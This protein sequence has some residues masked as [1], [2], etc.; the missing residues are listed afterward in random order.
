MKAFRFFSLFQLVNLSLSIQLLIAT[1]SAAN[2]GDLVT[3]FNTDGTTNEADLLL[4]MQS[5]GS[6]KGDPDYKLLQDLDQ[7]DDIDNFD[8]LLFIAAWKEDNQ[9]RSPRTLADV[10]NLM[11]FEDFLN[12]TPWRLGCVTNED[13]AC[14]NVVRVVSAGPAITVKG[15]PAIPV[16]YGPENEAPW[17][18]FYLDLENSL[19]IL[20]ADIDRPVTNLPGVSVQP[21]PLEM[22]GPVALIDSAMPT[23][24][25]RTV[26]SGTGSV[27]GDVILPPKLLGLFGMDDKIGPI[28]EDCEFDCGCEIDNLC[29]ELFSLLLVA[30]GH[31]SAQ[32]VFLNLG[33]GNIA[34]ITG[35]LEVSWEMIFDTG[36]LQFANLSYQFLGL[37]KFLAL[38]RLPELGDC[39][40]EIEPNDDFDSAQFVPLNECVSGSAGIEDITAD[41]FGFGI[42]PGEGG[43]LT[44]SV[45]Y[46]LGPGSFVSLVLYNQS[47]MP[48]Q[49]MG[50]NGGTS[51]SFNPRSVE[52]GDGFFVSVSPD[53]FVDYEISIHV[54]Q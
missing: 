23:P 49:T 6:Q 19:T 27:V 35:T 10:Y 26:G 50:L 8:L 36:G 24:G 11:G 45:E 1:S 13:G 14:D 7:D 39:L 43:L 54:T 40:A 28:C 34:P 44:V 31:G 22:S 33:K 20:A 41:Y 2:H 5:S 4:L 18:T 32:C 47:Q 46:E 16:T 29:E 15:R 37:R 53:G 12:G 38:E 42:A 25:S 30:A 51:F 52:P 3:D 17:N 21:Q 9:P 48:I